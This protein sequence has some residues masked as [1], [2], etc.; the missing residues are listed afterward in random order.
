MMTKLEAPAP[1]LMLAVTPASGR[2][3]YTDAVRAVRVNVVEA[4]KQNDVALVEY[5]Q[6]PRVI[7]QTVKISALSF[8][9]KSAVARAESLFAELLARPL[10]QPVAGKTASNAAANV[11]GQD[12]G[13]ASASR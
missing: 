5:R 2:V 4:D 1:A 9:A 8:S 7:R 6:G 10:L 12:A 11:T 13:I 3:P